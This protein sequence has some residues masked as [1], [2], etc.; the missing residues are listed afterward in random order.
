CWPMLALGAQ[1]WVGVAPRVAPWASAGPADR[2]RIGVRDEGVYRV[3][4]DEVALAAGWDAATVRAALAQGGVTLACGGSAVA[5]RADGDALLFY[6]Q[7]TRE[8]YAP[9][10][11]YWL[12][13]ES[14][15]VMPDKAAGP[16]IGATNVWFMHDEHC[17]AAFLAPYEPRDRRSS[18]GTLTNVLNF[19]EWI[20]SDADEMLRAQSRTVTL[21]G[22]CAD[23][24][25]GVAVRVEL[26]SYRDFTT[27]DEHRCEVRV[28]GV[29]GGVQE[30]AGEQAVTLDYVVPA[31]AVTNETVELTVR[32]AGDTLL[33]GEFMVLDAVVRYP[34]RYAAQDGVLTCTG[35]EDA[36]V[37]AAGFAAQDLAVWEVTDP[38]L[39]AALAEVCVAQDG[40]GGW[41][42]LFACG[43]AA[44]RYV[45]FERSRAEFAPSV[46]GVRDVDWS[47]PGEMPD[48]AIVTPPHRWWPG[49]AEAVTPLAAFREAQGLRTRVIDAEDLY[50]AFSDGLA[51]PE[52]FRRFSAAGVAQAGGPVLR[53]VLFAGHG[54]SDYKLEVFPPGGAGAYPTLF[55]LY[56]VPQVDA[57]ALGALL[58]PN[59]PVLGDTGGDAVPEVAVGRFLAT[60]ALELARMVQKTI[61]YELT[62]TW[63][64]KAVFSCDWQNVGAKYANFPGIAAATAAHFPEA[65]WWLETFY[66]APDQSYLA[67]LWR[68]TYYGTGISYELQEG[69]GFYYFVGHSSD[70][71]AGNTMA[72][73]LFDAPML[74]AAS[75]PFAPVALLMGCRMGRWTLLDLK[76]EQQ[77]IAE[78]GVRNPE[79]GFAAVVSAAGYMTTAEAAD[80]S[81]AFG[82]Q[83]AAG[84]RRLG[85]VWRGA[86]ATLGHDRALSL[87]HM[88]LLGDPSLCMRPDQTA[89]GTSAD[90]LL[91]QG[92]SGDPYADLL[93]QDGDGFVTW[94]EAQAGTGALV[95]GMRVSRLALPQAGSY[96]PLAAVPDP[97]A[98]ALALNIETLAGLA[99]TVVAADEPGSASWTP[100]PWRPVGG[101]AWTTGPIPGDWPLKQVEVPFEGSARR[102]FYKLTSEP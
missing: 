71:V 2:V 28:N 8:L 22:W 32:N 30:W 60:N 3:T 87:R 17:R 25:T 94:V 27:P 90:W 59:D 5:W 55:P 65:G 47:V 6:G 43:G 26:A 74:R 82:G 81:Q 80:F 19:G 50:N 68:D 78:A 11:V 61:R 9:E 15:T 66:P 64:R 40:A 31:G 76:S 33:A 102:R 88:V 20:G 48:L 12:A 51:H 83:I 58:L 37:A 77:A 73:K 34:R 7:P 63:K 93:D 96:D 75:W 62:E 69:A 52:A 23:T 89:R 86:F 36:V 13:L 4:A 39:P 46:S 101:A 1:H 95:G 54:G 29:S 97:A 41:Q 21:P 49:F 10:N 56:L 92:L 67:P 14:G 24:A 72:N 70:T 91:A 18:V 35:G 42:A 100:L 53:Y 16:G 57:V 85:D 99:F 79:S 84:A 98:P 38:V 45:V 44:A